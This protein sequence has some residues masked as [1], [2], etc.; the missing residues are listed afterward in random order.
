M[1]AEPLHIP[2]L[3]D[4]W[5]EGERAGREHE[6][7]KNQFIRFVDTNPYRDI[8]SDLPETT[9]EYTRGLC[10][11]IQRLK[12]QLAERD[13]RLTAFI[14]DLDAAGMTNVALGIND[15]LEGK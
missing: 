5:D 2:A 15:I 14:G 13:A 9:A 8:D 6:R 12:A 1:T 11:E 7:T 3:A 4:V 10:I